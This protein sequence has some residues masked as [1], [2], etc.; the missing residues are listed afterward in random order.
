MTNLQVRLRMA[1][2][3]MLLGFFR[4]CASSS[5]HKLNRSSNRRASRRAAS[6]FGDRPVS[7][8]KATNLT[9][10]SD[11]TCFKTGAL[12]AAGAS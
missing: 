10:S 3:W 1:M 7:K 9:S 12:E 8:W 11:R 2:A 6:S 4:W 5:T